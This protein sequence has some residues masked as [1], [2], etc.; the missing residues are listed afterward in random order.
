MPSKI[1]TSLT[2]E[3]LHEFFVRCAQL[4]GAKLKD[5][6]ALAEEFG[7]DISLM[8]A[9]SFKQGAFSDYLEELKAKR[10]MAETV[11][12]VAKD[13]LDLTAAAASALAAKV[14]DRSLNM[15]AAD[16]GTEEGNNISLAI[17]RLQAGNR[18]DKDL[19]RKLADSETKRA[20]V[21][22]RMDMQ[23]F[24]AAQAVIEHAKEIRS[25]MADAKLDGPAKTERVRKIL[26]GE[27]PADFKP[28]TDKGAQAE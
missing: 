10:D 27:K 24:D 17:S 19:A 28:V 15:S 16:I 18:G 11:A 6:A 13:G 12:L 22:Q 7:V 26:F 8:S 4:K 5:I 3:Q 25:V 20:A 21:E 14:F 9:R 23:Q 1:E 2:P